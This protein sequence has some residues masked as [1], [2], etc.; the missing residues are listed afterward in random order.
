MIRYR[1]L[2]LLLLVGNLNAL[3]KED[4]SFSLF[5]LCPTNVVLGCELNNFTGEWKKISDTKFWKTFVKKSEGSSIVI[6]YKNVTRGLESIGLDK[7]RLKKLFSGRVAFFLFNNNKDNPDQAFVFL[8]EDNPSLFEEILSAINLFGDIYSKIEKESFKGA[9]LL[10]VA[11]NMYVGYDSNRFVVCSKKNTLKNI[12]ELIDNPFVSVRYSESFLTFF[13]NI[14]TDSRQIFFIKDPSIL[15]D[16]KVPSD[17]KS[18]FI[19]GSLSPSVNIRIILKTE[20]ILDYERLIIYKP[21]LRFVPTSSVYLAGINVKNKIF[22]DTILFSYLLPFKENLK[23]RNV[24]TLNNFFKNSVMTNVLNGIL[25]CKFYSSS[26]NYCF[27]FNVNK[28]CRPESYAKS[29]WPDREILTGWY[30]NKSVL[31]FKEKSNEDFFNYLYAED[32]TLVVADS[33]KIL[34]ASISALKT[35][36]LYSSSLMKSLSKKNPVFIF[37]TSVWA[38]KKWADMAYLS[39][40]LIEESSFVTVSFLPLKT[41]GK[42]V[43]LE[44]NNYSSDFKR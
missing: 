32:D 27:I 14:S 30:D 44:L 42:G 33:L 29:L 40:A 15:G 34:A 11:S 2:L 28:G 26:T 12:F 18:V 20:S 17:V 10:S 1:V 39:Q 19:A 9:S 3:K 6:K 25:F 36:G 22:D 31:Y 8:I 37:Q 7:D 4:I 41:G 35:G 13:S 23:Q 43:I 5:A 16:K 24:D 38:N 21:L